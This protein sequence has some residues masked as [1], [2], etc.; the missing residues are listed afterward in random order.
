MMFKKLAEYFISS[1]VRERSGDLR[2]ERIFVTV[3]LISALADFL[4][5]GLAVSLK[6]PTLV[7][8]VLTNSFICIL[9]AY[10][11]KFGFNKYLIGHFFIAQHAVSFCFQAWAQGGLISPGSAA[12][13]LLPAV[14]MLMMGKRDATIWLIGTTVILTGFY[15]YQSANEPPEIGYDPDLR[16]YLF[17]SGV[18][19]TNITIFFILLA[20]ENNRNSRIRELDNKNRDLT[21]AQAEI[22]AQKKLRDRLF[23]V[24][25]H[26]LRGPV[27]YFVGLS[28]IGDHLLEN[29][30]F[31]GLK[32]MM[33]H[34]ETSSSQVSALLD[35][36]LNWASQELKEIPYNPEQI[37]V[38][39]LV[40]QLMTI[41]EPMGR[42]KS[43]ELVNAVTEEVTI[44]ADLNC[45]STIFRNLIQN[46]IK[47]TQEGRVSIS[48][49][50]SGEFVGIKV[51]DTGIGIES[52]KLKDLFQ[53]TEDRV[54][55]GTAGEKGVGLGLRLVHEF[56]KINQGNLEV[57]SEKGKGTAFT[58]FLPISA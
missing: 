23:A 37:D 9:L 57:E 8:L 40:Q 27:S 55:Y 20:Y 16:E 11:Y 21:E 22:H 12:F 42:A 36:L 4:G 32:N 43:I 19:G 18:L 54:S 3:I 56:T 10:L 31:E 51:A 15:L 48:T 33:S 47:F 45:T 26:D 2:S 44:W 29:R 34:L 14:A 52:D 39:A 13:F 30:D 24:V 5:T 17:F 58:V 38:N 7:Y 6:S 28:K 25:S 41:F 46:A 49:S 35:N 53:F 1:K 50:Q